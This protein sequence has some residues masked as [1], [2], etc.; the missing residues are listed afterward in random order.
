[1]LSGG[2]DEKSFSI[3]LSSMQAYKKRNIEKRVSASSE[4][5]SFLLSPSFFLRLFSITIFTTL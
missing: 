3:F 2:T 1:M 4:R 5:S